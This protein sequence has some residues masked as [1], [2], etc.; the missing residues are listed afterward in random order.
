ML[1]SINVRQPRQQHQQRWHN[2][3]GTTACNAR[4]KQQQQQ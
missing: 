3:L 1:Q 4:Y 2:S